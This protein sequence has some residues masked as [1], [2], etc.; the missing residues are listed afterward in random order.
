MSGN[1]RFLESLIRSGVDAHP[2]DPAKQSV[3]EL[4]QL[5]FCKAVL[6][7]HGK[8]GEDGILQGMLEYFTNSIYRFWSISKRFKYG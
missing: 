5:G 6:M 7:T 8:V 1:V 4:K 3:F 2:F